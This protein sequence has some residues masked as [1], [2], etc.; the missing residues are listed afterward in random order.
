MPNIQQIIGSLYIQRTY[1]IYVYNLLQ[2]SIHWIYIT[3]PD[4]FS[5]WYASEL[6][7]VGLLMHQDIQCQMNCSLLSMPR[8]WS[9]DL[10]RSSASITV[11]GNIM[12]GSWHSHGNMPI[13]VYWKLCNYTLKKDF[14]MQALIPV[15]TKTSLSH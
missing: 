8:L 7:K 14:H 2:L 3:Q 4:T 11:D 13:Q 1:R 12:L 15:C 10:Y 5:T 6:L 9:H